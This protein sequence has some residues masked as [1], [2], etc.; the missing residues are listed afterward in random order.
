MHFFFDDEIIF[1]C[2]ESSHRNLD[3]TSEPLSSVCS[4][5]GKWTVP[6]PMCKGKCEKLITVKSGEEACGLWTTENFPEPYENDMSC[7]VRFQAEDVNTRFKIEIRFILLEYKSRFATSCSSLDRLEFESYTNEF[8]EL[9]ESAFIDED[10]I[11]ESKICAHSASYASKSFNLGK[12]VSEKECKQKDS[13][14]MCGPEFLDDHSN[15]FSSEWKYWVPKTLTTRTNEFVAR[16]VSDKDTRKTGVAFTWWTVNLE[17]STNQTC[18]NHSNYKFSNET[19]SKLCNVTHLRDNRGY[20]DEQY[21]FYSDIYHVFYIIILVYALAK[22]S[23]FLL[24]ILWKCVTCKYKKVDSKKVMNEDDEGS[25]D[26]DSEF[27]D[28]SEY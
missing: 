15:L 4:A 26:D 14:L 20:Q 23:L 19:I 16:F 21:G 17:N 6:Q 27:S 22:F 10:G 24:K 28:D 1:K 25:S 5:S 11:A 9:S 7:P 13:C 18:L 3:G 8:S 12:S 2:P